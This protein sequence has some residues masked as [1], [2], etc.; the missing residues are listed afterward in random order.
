M[1]KH[2]YIIFFITIAFS[3]LR[4]KT[5]AQKLAYNKSF[6]LIKVGESIWTFPPNN[7]THLG[8]TTN[9]KHTGKYSLVMD[10]SNSISLPNDKEAPYFYL[11]LPITLIKEKK[12]V[13]LKA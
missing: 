3:L 1:L 2:L 6:E 10:G 7:T 9:Y 5:T 4:N 13:T 12:T 8:F 11:D